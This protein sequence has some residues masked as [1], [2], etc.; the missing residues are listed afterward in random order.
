MF[1]PFPSAQPTNVGFR[2]IVVEPHCMP[3]YLP[4]NFPVAG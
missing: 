4:T 2:P 1:L 3:E